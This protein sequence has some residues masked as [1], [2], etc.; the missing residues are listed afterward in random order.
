MI[1]NNLGFNPQGAASI[2]VTALQFAYTNNDS[3]SEA[4]YIFRRTVFDDSKNSTTLL[5]T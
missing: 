5:T 2:T 3:V 1:K 4:V